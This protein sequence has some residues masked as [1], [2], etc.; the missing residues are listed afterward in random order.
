[1]CACVSVCVD[2]IINIDYF[3]YCVC[4]NILLITALIESLASLF[5]SEQELKQMYYVHLNTALTVRPRVIVVVCGCVRLNI[6][7]FPSIVVNKAMSSA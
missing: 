7:C 1:M 4:F 6:H 2:S 3:M 5:G